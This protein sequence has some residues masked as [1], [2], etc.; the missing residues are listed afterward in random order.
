MSVEWDPAL[1]LGHKGI[2]GQHRELFRRLGALV[3]AMETGEDHEIPLLFDLLG[4]YLEKHFAAEEQAMAATAYPG[5]NVHTAAHARFIREYAELRALYE[6]N[7]ATSG[8]AVKTRTWIEDW[9]RKH[10]RHVDHPFAR[11]LRGRVERA[12]AAP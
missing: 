8:V 11:H 2:D 5:A 10:I 1:A 6:A 9:L 3:S 4:E 7:G 12:A